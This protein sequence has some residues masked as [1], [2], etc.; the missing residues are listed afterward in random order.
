MVLLRYSTVPAI[1]YMYLQCT[2]INQQIQ[3]L[4]GPKKKRE[5]FSFDRIIG[6]GSY[7]TVSKCKNKQAVVLCSSLYVD[8]H[9]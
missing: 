7:S 3:D 2:C 4:E 1:R 5:D 6:E 9:M 8:K